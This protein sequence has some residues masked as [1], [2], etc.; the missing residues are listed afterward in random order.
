MPHVLTDERGTDVCLVRIAALSIKVIARP[1]VYACLLETVRKASDA[2][3]EVN[4]ND[5][6]GCLALLHGRNDIRKDA[7]RR[8]RPRHASAFP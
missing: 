3:K 1:Y 2:T 8:R 4:G 5:G 7:L 6:L